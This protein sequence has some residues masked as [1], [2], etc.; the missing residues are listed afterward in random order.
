MQ[1]SSKLGEL[2]Q[3]KQTPQC[4]AGP[5]PHP[6]TVK[7]LTPVIFTQPNDGSPVC[8]TCVKTFKA[9]VSIAV[10]KTCGH[11]LCKDCTKKFLKKDKKCTVCETKVKDIISIAVEGTGFAA[12]GK[13]EAVKTTPAFM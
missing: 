4:F 10:L 1:P 9:G 3:T 2:K 5:S 12:G 6:I 8:P 11:A 13:T 7:K